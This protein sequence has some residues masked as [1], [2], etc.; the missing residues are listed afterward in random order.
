MMTARQWP[1]TGNH[2]GQWP[3]E[4]QVLFKHEAECRYSNPGSGTPQ[5]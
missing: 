5:A 3:A 4:A 2:S 1:E